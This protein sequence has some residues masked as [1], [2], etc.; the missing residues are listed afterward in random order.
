VSVDREGR[1]QAVNACI[2]V[3]PVLDGRQ[4]LT[5]EHLAHADGTLHPVQQAMVDHHGSQCGFCTPGFV[6]SLFALRTEAKPDRVT[7]N[8]ALAGNLCRCT[9][10]RPIVDAALQVC[11]GAEIPEPLALPVPEGSLTLSHGGKRWFSPR[12]RDE[13]AQ[14]LLDHPEAVIVAGATDVGL[15]VTKQHQMLPLTVSL[16]AVSDIGSVV[17]TG[18]TIQI[19]AGAT[20]QDALPVLEHHYL[21]FG[22]MIRRH[23]RGYS[24]AHRYNRNSAHRR[25]WSARCSSHRRHRSRP[26]RLL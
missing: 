19:G 17:E 6:M 12:S 18:N 11:I 1:H 14:T 20:Y 10:Y 22:V 8:E 9:G 13:L 24:Q 2:M 4:L 25:S 7:I 5:V 21:D 23:R 15:W 3:L 16:D 26:P